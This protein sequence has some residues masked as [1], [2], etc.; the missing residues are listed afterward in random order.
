MYN[1]GG[2]SADNFIEYNITYSNIEGDDNWIPNG[3]GNLS[4][5]PL[6]VDLTNDDYHLLYNSPCIDA[7][8]PDYIDPDATISDMGAFYY[9]QNNLGDLNNDEIINIIDVVSLINLILNDEYNSI[10]DMNLDGALN[11]QDAIIIINI[12]LSI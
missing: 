5:S 9:H 2:Y 12:I 8:S 6:F 3:I 7:G 11:V 1:L 10:A 4:I